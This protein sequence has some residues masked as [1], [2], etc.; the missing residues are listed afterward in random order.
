M[1]L[2]TENITKQFN[3]LPAIKDVNLQCVAGE[4]IG[5]GGPNGSGKTTLLNLLSGYV[6][7]T[8]GQIRYKGKDI[9]HLSI[10]DRSRMGITRTHQNGRIFPKHTVAENIL[11][12]SLSSDF[13]SLWRL[14]TD[15]AEMN[16]VSV[17]GILESVGLF[18]IIKKPAGELSFGQKRRLEFAMSLILRDKKSLFLFDEPTTGMDIAFI[19]TLIGWI[20]RLRNEGKII[21]LVEHNLSFMKRIADKL[22][23]LVAGQVIAKGSPGEVLA[24]PE[25]KD[26]YL[27]GWNHAS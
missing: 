4:V 18:S 3:G 17:S 20:Q 6:L 14:T 27:S 15:F 12:A 25:V 2:S 23:V 7:P 19:E 26:S 22:V 13:R 24:K 10:V 21:I 16:N 9:T 5:I 1:T 8:S 11:I